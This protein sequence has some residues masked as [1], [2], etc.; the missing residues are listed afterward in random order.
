MGPC[1]VF[2]DVKE[3]RI[4]NRIVGRVKPPY[5]ARSV[6]A[7]RVRKKSK[8]GVEQSAQHTW[9]T[10]TAPICNDAFVLACAAHPTCSSH[11]KNWRDGCKHQ[12]L[13]HGSFQKSCQ[14]LDWTW[15]F[16]STHFRQFEGPSRSVVFTDSD[17]DWLSDN[18]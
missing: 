11:R 7:S 9:T 5:G 1:A 6:C 4:L 17:H 2:G 14:E 8:S 3:V 10:H 15:T 16:D 18:T 13:R 12:Q